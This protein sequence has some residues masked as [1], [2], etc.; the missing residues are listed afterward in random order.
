MIFLLLCSLCSLINNAAEQQYQAIMAMTS[1]IME[2]SMRKYLQLMVVLILSAVGANANS[3]SD[4][5]N[6]Y[7]PFSSPTSGSVVVS[8]SSSSPSTSQTMLETYLQTFPIND[9][10]N[11]LTTVHQPHHHISTVEGEKEKTTASNEMIY[12]SSSSSTTRLAS[13]AT[14][15]SQSMDSQ[16]PVVNP[17]LPSILTSTYN[18]DTEQQPTIIEVPPHEMLG[19]G[20]NNREAIGIQKVC[21]QMHEQF[22]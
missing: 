6:S 13:L 9:T 7:N 16:T 2:K 4:V 11:V 20:P 3:G 12:S 5:N 8:S 1:S 17:S 10:Q 19:C 18:Q 15:A 21:I 22:S 14:E